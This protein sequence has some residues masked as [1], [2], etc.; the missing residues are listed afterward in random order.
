MHSH[1]KNTAINTNNK[2]HTLQICVSLNSPTKKPNDNMLA[3]SSMT[4]HWP[5]QHLSMLLEQ[6][7]QRLF[8]GKPTNTAVQLRSINVSCTTAWVHTL[9]DTTVIHSACSK[10]HQQQRTRAPQNKI[11][12]YLTTTM[13][14]DITMLH[15]I[16]TPVES[17]SEKL[18]SLAAHLPIK[19]S[20]KYPRHL[21]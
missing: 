12:T 4:E 3:Y 9:T 5:T 19:F 13:N 15:C 20:L 8:D 7:L 18:L 14:T 1:I 2:S 6:N 17:L 16:G 10:Y 11:N 21:R